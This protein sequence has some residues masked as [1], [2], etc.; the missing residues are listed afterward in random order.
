MQIGMHLL[1][2]LTLIPNMYAIY[3]AF[4]CFHKSIDY[5]TKILEN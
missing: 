5:A 2:L 1:S 3:F 4:N